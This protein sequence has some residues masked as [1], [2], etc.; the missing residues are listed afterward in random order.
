MGEYLEKNIDESQAAS[1]IE[2]T[3]GYSQLALGDYFPTGFAE[4]D[5][6]FE[7]GLSLGSFVC[8]HGLSGHDLSSFAA[9]LS[10]HMAER[11]CVS[12]LSYRIDEEHFENLVT[13]SYTA[14][15]PCPKVNVIRLNHSNTSAELLRRS[16]GKVVMMDIYEAV[17]QAGKSSDVVVVDGAWDCPYWECPYWEI[18]DTL[19]KYLQEA[20]LSTGSLIIATRREW[21]VG[22]RHF[23]KEADRRVYD[24]YLDRCADEEEAEVCGRP[25]LGTADILAVDRLHGLWNPSITIA[26][27]ANTGVFRSFLGDKQ[28]PGWLEIPI[29]VSHPKAYISSASTNQECCRGR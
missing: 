17:E 27:Y 9:Y 5:E 15:G 12:V 14:E 28:D 23:T 13:K 18:D 10:A 16:D 19:D 29:G 20:A 6:A 7:G 24:L 4:V 26:H 3:E 8:V 2:K 22:K 1:R 11:A 21:F 25:P